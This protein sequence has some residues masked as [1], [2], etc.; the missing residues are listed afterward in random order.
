MAATIYIAAQQPPHAVPLSKELLGLSIEGDRFEDWTGPLGQPNQFTHQALRNL[1]D[2]TGT[3]CPIRWGG[4]PN[5]QLEGEAKA[6]LLFFLQPIPRIN[7]RLRMAYGPQKLFWL[8]APPRA[9]L[10]LNQLHQASI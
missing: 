7:T 2:R 10:T 5:I 8:T 9:H 3:P 6:D 4:E 1:S